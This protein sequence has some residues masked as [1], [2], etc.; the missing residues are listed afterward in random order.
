MHSLNTG[1]DTDHGFPLHFPCVLNTLRAAGARIGVVDYDIGPYKTLEQLS[2]CTLR[3][4][5]AV[6]KSRDDGQTRVS[7]SSRAEVEPGR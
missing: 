4:A 1:K 6:D 5:T 2:E 3:A 7:E